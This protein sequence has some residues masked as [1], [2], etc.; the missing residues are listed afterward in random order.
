MLTCVVLI[1][2]FYQ[3]LKLIDFLLDSNNSMYYWCSAYV[4]FRLLLQKQARNQHTF[5]LKL[6]QMD[7]CTNSIVEF[8]RL[9]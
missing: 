6:V 4:R 3:N 1:K 7:A 5:I 8:T 2:V 9:F